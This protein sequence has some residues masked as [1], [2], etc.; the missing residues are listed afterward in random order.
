MRRAWI[1]IATVFLLNSLAMAQ[2]AQHPLT[3][4]KAVEMAVQ[5]NPSLRES[6]EK[7]NQAAQQVPLTRAL[8]FPNVNLTGTSYYR[9]DMTTSSALGYDSDPHNQYVVDMKVTQ[10]L[11]QIGSIA[12]IHAAE[13]GR[14]MSRKDSEIS[15]RDL[16][17]QVIQAYFQVV[18]NMRNVDTLLRQQKIQ[19][20]SLAVVQHREH[21]GRSQLL[22]VLQVKTQLALL[23]AQIATAQN[24]LQVAEAILANLL[25]DPDAKEFHVTGELPEPTLEQVDHQIDLRHFTLP[26]LEKNQFAID[27]IRDQKRVSLGQNLPNLVAIA[28]YQMNSPDQVTLVQNDNSHSWFI[29]L[30]LNIPIFS[31]LSSIYQQRSLQSQETQLEFERVNTQNQLTLQQVSNRKNLESAHQTIVSGD[32]A[33]KLAVASSNEAKRNFRLGTIDL[34]QFFSVEQ[35][36]VQAE[37][38][39]NTEKYNYLVALG[40]YYA[41]CGQ[42]LSKL[43]DLLESFVP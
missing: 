13:A 7:I 10:P 37:S 18:L 30:Q 9:K 21:T 24:Q 20:E 11:L 6:R 22:D 3:L 12:A 35:A 19:N 29:G 2:D 25:G 40:N 32:E 26:E 17:N 27:Q 8:L 23:A 38:S 4:R 41:A 1:M 16:T 14:E 34:V 43:V 39:L 15:T 5:Q 42:D 31:G 36:Y 28:D 33:L